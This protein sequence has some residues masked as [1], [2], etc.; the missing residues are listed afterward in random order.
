MMCRATLLLL[1]ASLSGAVIAIA[2]GGT[3]LGILGYPDHSCFKPNKPFKPYSFNSSWEIDSYNSQVDSYNM[4][5]QLY[6]S[7][8]KEYLER[9]GND[10]KRIEEKMDEAIAQEKR[11]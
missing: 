3:N 6:V 7:C 9:A 4:G 11:P 10:I 5:R 8:V 2:S 1:L